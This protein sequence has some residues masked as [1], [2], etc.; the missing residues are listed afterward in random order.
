MR[1]FVDRAEAG[2]QLAKALVGVVP[3]E[4]GAVLGL[5]RGG[6]PV[7]AEVATALGLPLDVLCVRKL[8]VPLHPELAMGAIASGGAVVLNE[9]VLATLS[10]SEAALDRVLSDERAELERRERC[11]RGDAP[12]LDVR[13]RAVILVDDGLATG[14]TMAAA[15]RALRTLA[16]SSIVAAVP[17]GSQEAVARIEELADRVV[18]LHA[19]MFFGS[20][21]SFYAAFDQ[22]SDEEVR[23]LLAAA[24]ERHLYRGR[25]GH[26]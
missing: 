23:E 24:Q 22:T 8:G 26:A 13:N 12:A 7:A 18:C 10:P 17:V 1:R 16:P 2:R 20:V 3:G 5:P 4:S 6:V 9:D 25:H 11:F 21:G 14:A 15:V 19:P